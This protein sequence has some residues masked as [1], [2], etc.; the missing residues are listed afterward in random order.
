MHGSVRHMSCRTQ[1]GQDSRQ[2]LHGPL[3]PSS[4]IQVLPCWLLDQLRS[5]C[6]SHRARH[7]RCCWVT[8]GL[9]LAAPAVIGQRWAGGDPPGSCEVLAQRGSL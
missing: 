4:L 5:V 1:Q 7:G 9:A 3:P 2:V 6:W 8:F